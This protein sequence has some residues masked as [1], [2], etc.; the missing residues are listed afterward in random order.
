[1]KGPRLFTS[2][3]SRSWSGDVARTGVKDSPVPA[4]AMTMSILE[5]LV[6]SSSARLLAAVSEVLSNR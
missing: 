3:Y 5:I 2:K 4:L 1:L 6:A